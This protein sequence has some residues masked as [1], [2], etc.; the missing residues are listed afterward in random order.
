MAYAFLGEP[1][2][3]QHVV[4]HI[5]TNRQ[6]NRP[7]NLRWLTRL[8]NAL[9]NPITRAKIENIC[10]S[11]EAFINDP[12]ILPLPKFGVMA[13]IEEGM[14]YHASALK[15]LKIISRDLSAR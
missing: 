4:D 13:V 14:T 12:T 2:T 6:N 11:I 7:E 5:D 3:N 9:L 15:H 10:G 8:E 1:P